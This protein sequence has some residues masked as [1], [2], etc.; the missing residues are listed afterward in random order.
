MKTIPT[1]TDAVI[2]ERVHQLMW[3]GRISQVSMAARMG[4]TQPG[5]SKKLRG[6]RKWLASELAVA[7]GLLGVSMDELCPATE[8]TPQLADLV[9]R[10]GAPLPPLA[11]V[12]AERELS[13]R[14]S[15]D[16]DPIYGVAA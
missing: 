14:S 6:E 15:V 5:L 11:D 12:L 3:R 1:D 2:G 4:M 8:R 10:D 13:N 16:N 9:R 7:A